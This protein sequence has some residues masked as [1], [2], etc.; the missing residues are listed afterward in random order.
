MAKKT[1]I[2]SL[3]RMFS[4]RQNSPQFELVAFSAFLKKY[5]QQFVQDDPNLMIYLDLNSELLVTELEQLKQNNQIEYIPGKN[6]NGK[7]IVSH[8]YIDKIK[9]RYKVLLEKSD[10][11]FPLLHNFPKSA[12][13]RFLQTI[14]LGNEFME[15]LPVSGEKEFLYSLSLTADVPTVIFPSS[16][17]TDRI[18]QVCLTKMQLY[19]AKDESFDYSLKRLCIANPGKEFSVKGFLSK[20]KSNVR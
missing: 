3:L 20:L 5:A 17:P 7:I 13:S 4:L 19:L 10:E 2:A 8:Y 12:I 14:D 15:R 9:Q 1:D 16:L 11:P 18:I 6:G